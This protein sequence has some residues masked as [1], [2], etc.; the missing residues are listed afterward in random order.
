MEY[1]YFKNH[2]I[3][4]LKFLYVTSLNIS[5]FEKCISKISF[6]ILTDN[7]QKLLFSDVENN[8]Q[9]L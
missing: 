4:I 8:W 3:F 9:V 2:N 5:D 6:K 1:D 7:L